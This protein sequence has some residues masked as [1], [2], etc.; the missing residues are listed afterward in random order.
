MHKK[1]AKICFWSV[2]CCFML[3][4]LNPGCGIPSRKPLTQELTNE[5]AGLVNNFF[6]LLEHPYDENKTR[7]SLMA[8]I[9][10]EELRNAIEKSLAKKP[11]LTLDYE[12]E[13]LNIEI[14][15]GFVTRNQLTAS[16]SGELPQIGL[17]F[18]NHVFHFI[19]RN[20]QWLINSF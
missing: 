16:V 7:E 5:I 10:D 19:N 15:P 2:L 12:P 20:N 17:S 11:R 1:Y 6:V 8:L 3:V 14:D 18:E 4:F 9:A 13:E